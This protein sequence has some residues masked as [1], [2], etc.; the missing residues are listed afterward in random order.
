[1]VI[2][3]QSVGLGKMTTESCLKDRPPCLFLAVSSC[4]S[5]FYLLANM[6]SFSTRFMYLPQQY[7]Y[8][9]N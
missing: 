2:G 4:P 9:L 3:S 1:M 7:S 8:Q 6:C 5:F